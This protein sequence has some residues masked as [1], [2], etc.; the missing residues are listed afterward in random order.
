MPR[1]RSKYTDRCSMQHIY[2]IT[3][4]HFLVM[5]LFSLIFLPRKIGR[6]LSPLSRCAFTMHLESLK[7]HSRN[8]SL[9]FH[10][11]F[12]ISTSCKMH[13]TVCK[14]IN[15]DSHGRLTFQAQRPA[16]L[17]C[18]Y[19]NFTFA[20]VSR[21]LTFLPTPNPALPESCLRHLCEITTRPEL[22]RQDS[23]GRESLCSFTSRLSYT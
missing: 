10:A 9:H 23:A 1:K 16:R 13:I 19:R 20:V 21:L 11:Y 2:L 17:H 6:F 14:R 5:V 4:F 3:E 12:F 18:I 22:F 8:T 15:G 7:P